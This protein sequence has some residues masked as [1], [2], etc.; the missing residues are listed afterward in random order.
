MPNHVKKKFCSYNTFFPSFEGLMIKRERGPFIFMKAEQQMLM[1]QLLF[2]TGL[3][4]K[5]EI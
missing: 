3:T 5:T 4:S 2:F 1:H